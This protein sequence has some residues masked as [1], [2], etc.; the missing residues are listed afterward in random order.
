MT[1]QII[2]NISNWQEDADYTRNLLDQVGTADDFFRFPRANP[3]DFAGNDIIDTSAL[4]VGVAEANQPTIGVIIY[5]GAGND[6]IRGSQAGD[7][8]AGGSGNDTIY[9][10]GG[11]DHVYGDSGFNVDVIG[12]TVALANRALSVAERLRLAGPVLT[13]PTSNTSTAFNADGLIAG[14]DLIFGAT[15]DDMIFG[16]HGIITQVVETA[17]PIFPATL[18]IRTTRE[19]TD[20]RTTQPANG[21]NDE[22]HGEAGI[23]R[24][25]G[26]NGND[27]ITGDGE[28]DVIFG[29]HGFINYILGDANLGH[30]LW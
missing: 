13:V 11:L 2:Q 17:A 1:V 30:G 21:G 16:D 3:Y 28:R 14:N 4:F 23:D 12:N 8:I 20:I 27:V 18:K 15:G 9:A 7:Q 5:G 10:N 19:I 26:G 6:I 24:I 22:I 29:D 25:L